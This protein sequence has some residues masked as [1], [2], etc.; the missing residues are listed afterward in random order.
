MMKHPLLYLITILL[1][2]SLATISC[3]QETGKIIIATN[4]THPPFTYT[5]KNTSEMVG[6]DIDLIKA[7]AKKAAL[8]IEFVN[9]KFESLLEGMAKQQYDAAI[10]AISI[11]ENRK[12]D[13][14]FSDSY[15]M[16]GHVITLR[17]DNT[18]ITGKESLPGK[19]VGVQTGTTSAIDVSEIKGANMK[20]YA[21]YVLAF[22]AL[23]DSAVDAVVSD[24]TIA[25]G[26]VSQNPTKIKITGA[27]FSLENYGIAVNKNKP[28]LL[29]K[30]NAGLK[31]LK[32]EGFLDQLSQ[33]WLPPSVSTKETV[34]KLER[35]ACRGKCPVY[36]LTVKGNGTVI[37]EGKDFVQTKGVKEATISQDEIKKLVS[38]FEKVNYFSLSDSYTQVVITDFPYVT[39]SITAGGKT[40][41]IRHYHGDLDA[42]KSLKELEDKI[43][44]I[45][46]S[47]QWVK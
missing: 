1:G 6:Y 13:M 46:N 40:K 39:T 34:I 35:T 25:L 30:I 4:A 7:I 42:P 36:T 22:Q 29:S 15:F 37:Y 47:A 27:S 31:S 12:K 33:K 23:M 21:D 28:E 17:T 8:N 2:L 44:E 26:Y 3:G 45:V 19:T 14:L 5:D 20:A 10:G 9:V 16:A 41:T 32:N 24:D 38:E 18:A 11:T 43:D